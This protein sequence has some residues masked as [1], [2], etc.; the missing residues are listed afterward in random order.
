MVAEFGCYHVANQTIMVEAVL[1]GLRANNAFFNN[2]NNTDAAQVRSRV[3]VS[4]VG[5][6]APSS[7]QSSAQAPHAR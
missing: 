2:F 3:P 1:R 7:A 6:V 5:V 4:R